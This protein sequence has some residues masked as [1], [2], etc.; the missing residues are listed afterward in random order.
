MKSTNIICT[1]MGT[2]NAHRLAKLL[3][4]NVRVEKVG[5][6]WQ[7]QYRLT[8]SLGLTPA[9]GRWTYIERVPDCKCRVGGAMID[10]RRPTLWGA[11]MHLFARCLVDYWYDNR[12]KPVLQPGEEWDPK[13]HAIRPWHR[14]LTYYISPCDSATVAAAREFLKHYGGRPVGGM[15]ATRAYDNRHAAL[16]IW[17]RHRYDMPDLPLYDFN[18]KPEVKSDED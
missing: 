2:K 13:K 6:F 12:T 3:G 4:Y 14:E 11:A 8:P 10:T 15:F 9:A 1:D 18:Q 5:K 16:V 17:W 7:V